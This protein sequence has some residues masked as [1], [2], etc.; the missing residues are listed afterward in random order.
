MSRVAQESSI[1]L[2]CMVEL[3]CGFSDCSSFVR[4]LP[5]GRLKGGA[6]TVLDEDLGPN[7]LRALSGE[8]YGSI[9]VVRG[10][11]IL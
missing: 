6:D 9:L 2:I 3:F 11:P 7:A 5:R 8:V 4:G 10:Q 1:L